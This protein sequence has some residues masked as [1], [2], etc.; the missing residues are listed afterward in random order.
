ML[1]KNYR[2][3]NERYEK[4]RPDRVVAHRRPPGQ[5]RTPLL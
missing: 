4:D 3:Q 1:A 5:I 2:Q